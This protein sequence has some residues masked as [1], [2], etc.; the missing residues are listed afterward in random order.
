MC[1]FVSQTSFLSLQ[2]FNFQLGRCTSWVRLDWHQISPWL[3]ITGARLLPRSPTSLM[4]QPWSMKTMGS[5]R[6]PSGKFGSWGTFINGV[7]STSGFFSIL[8]SFLYRGVYYYNF[9]CF[10]FYSSDVIVSQKN[11]QMRMSLTFQLVVAYFFN[12]PSKYDVIQWGEVQMCAKGIKL[13][14]TKSHERKPRMY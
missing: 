5:H 9:S 10:P 7:V 11:V 4:F 14:C 6:L 2:S 8:S 13:L 1:K 3:E 12:G